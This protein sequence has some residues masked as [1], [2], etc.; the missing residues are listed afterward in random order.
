MALLDTIH[1]PQDVRALPPE[2]LGR[3]AAEIRAFLVDSKLVPFDVT[4]RK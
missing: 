4:G 1:G 3:L 2:A